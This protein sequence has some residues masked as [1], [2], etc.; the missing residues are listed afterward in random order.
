MRA[1]RYPF[2]AWLIYCV[3]DI[4]T[5]STTSSNK[6]DSSGRIYI[7]SS[8][9]QCYCRDRNTDDNV[10][11]TFGRAN[12]SVWRTAY[13]VASPTPIPE[14]ERRDVDPCDCFACKNYFFTCLAQFK[15]FNRSIKIHNCVCRMDMLPPIPIYKLSASVRSLWFIFFLLLSSSVYS[16]LPLTANNWSSAY[17]RS[18]TMASKT[19]WRWTR[20]LRTNNAG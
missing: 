4:H 2:T 7:C 8:V 3:G 1:A 16:V 18:C 19:Y 10:L 13:T 15:S 17:R 14:W 9:I 20:T 12:A 11:S 6:W 5:Y